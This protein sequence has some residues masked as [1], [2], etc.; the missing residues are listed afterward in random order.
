MASLS[1]FLGKCKFLE[2]ALHKWIFATLR[3]VIN[4]YF[5][6]SISSRRRPNW[7]ASPGWVSFSRRM[8][9][10]QATFKSQ[11]QQ[12]RRSCSHKNG[13]SANP[14][15]CIWR[16]GV[17]YFGRR[18]TGHSLLETLCTWSPP[19]SLH[20]QRLTWLGSDYCI[21]TSRRSSFPRVSLTPYQL[22]G[23]SGWRSQV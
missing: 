17:S 10:A 12:L 8:Q 18:R 16:S 3:W 20:S 7:N 13:P 15:R 5:H 1:G 14:Y 4:Q 6:L 2:F 19:L 23:P 9:Q 11:T 21:D 22:H